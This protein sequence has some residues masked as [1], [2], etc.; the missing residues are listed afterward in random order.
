MFMYGGI[1]LYPPA[2]FT[3]FFPGGKRDGKIKGPIKLV[4]IFKN[5]VDSTFLL[6]RKEKLH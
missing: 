2:L 3:Y 5:A 1:N 4:L 6:F